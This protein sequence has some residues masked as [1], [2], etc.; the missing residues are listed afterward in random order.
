MGGRHRPAP[1]ADCRWFASLLLRLLE[2]GPPTLRLLRR[3]PVPEGPPRYVLAVPYRD[4][5]TTW[6]G[7]RETGAWW[8]REPLHESVPPAAVRAPARDPE[9]PRP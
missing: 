6:A 1:P 9:E 8:S 5:F 7:W 4:R 3:N 2:S